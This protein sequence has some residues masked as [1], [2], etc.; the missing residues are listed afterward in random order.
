MPKKCR[1][2]AGTALR[3]VVGAKAR[4]PACGTEIARI[5]GECI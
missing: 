3:H 5:I 2:Q 1:R 4:L